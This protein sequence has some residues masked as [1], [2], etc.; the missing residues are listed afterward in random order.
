MYVRIIFT[1]HFVE[2]CVRFDPF[3]IENCFGI[4]AFQMKTLSPH[5]CTN[6]LLTWF[7]TVKVL[8]KI[9]F[10]QCENSATMLFKELTGVINSIESSIKFLRDR[11]VLHTKPPICPVCGRNMTEIKDNGRGDR[12]VWRCKSHKDAKKSIRYGSPLEKSHLKLEDFIVLTYLWAAKGTIKMTAECT[13]MSKKSVITW[14]KFYRDVCAIW[15]AS[16][17]PVIGAD[18]QR[19]LSEYLWR[20]K[21]GKNGTSAFNAIL[22][23]IAEQY[24][25]DKERS[26]IL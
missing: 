21:N 11:Q 7:I 12:R 10:F 24:S 5:I 14:F 4:Y 22:R 23:H 26:P 18:V 16:N 9:L 8:C 25:D 1:V 2:K 13:G 20:K 6:Q 15:M 19:A 3:P 17:P